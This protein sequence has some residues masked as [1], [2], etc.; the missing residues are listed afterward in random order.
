[1]LKYVLDWMVR[2]PSIDTSIHMSVTAYILPLCNSN[3]CFVRS[4]GCKGAIY[5]IGRRRAGD[6]DLTPTREPLN[7]RNHAGP[8]EGKVL[9]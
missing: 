9:S 1:M 5:V 4:N 6:L 2:P 8:I 3:V 7:L